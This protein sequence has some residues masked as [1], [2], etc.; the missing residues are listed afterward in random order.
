MSS[1]SI[2]GAL[3]EGFVLRMRP[4]ELLLASGIKV[5]AEVVLWQGQTWLL[6]VVGSKSQAA[7]QGA[8]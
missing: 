3:W 7:E 2:L 6:W 1:G 8:G 4:W 5:W